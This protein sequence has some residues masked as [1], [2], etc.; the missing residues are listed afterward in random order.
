MINKFASILFMAFFLCISSANASIKNDSIDS[1]LVEDTLYNSSSSFMNRTQAKSE[2]KPI[3]IKGYIE[4]GVNSEDKFVRLSYRLIIALFIVF[5]STF[6]F[7]ISNR[8]VAEYLKRKKLKINDRI[9]ELIALYINIEKDSDV[10]IDEVFNELKSMQKNKTARRIILKYILSVDLAFAGESNLQLRKLYTRLNYHKRAMHKLNSESWS[11]RAKTIR[12]LSQMD[13]EETTDEIR[14]SLN[15]I[16]PVLRLEAGIALLKID[17]ANPFSF[18][19]VERE[20]TA[21]QQM[22]LLEII[23]NSKLLKVPSFKKWLHSKQD[24]IVEFSIKLISYYQQ[25]DALED[26]KL[27]IKH[28]NASIRFEVVKCLGSLEM[29]EVIADLIQV[30]RLEKDEKVRIQS[31]KSVAYLGGE[32]AILFLEEVLHS[33]ISVEMLTAAIA[34]RELGDVGVSKLYE[35][36]NTTD[37]QLL[38][39]LRHALDENLIIYK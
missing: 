13:I 4:A 15:H 2:L 5:I 23:R 35:H 30:Y 36:T 24:S 1:L 20:L 28:K 6:I 7:I 37:M 32:S 16:N 12:E 19:E 21:W 25:L 3:G 38:K 31:I 9:E 39:V 10:E 11:V 29:E 18:L 27:L 22:N 34:L 14:K 26:L 8:F 33:S 17:K